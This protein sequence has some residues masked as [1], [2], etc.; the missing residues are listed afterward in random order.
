M[1]GHSLLLDSGTHPKKD[2]KESL[3]EFGLVTKAP[4]AV[5]ISH[6]HIDHCGSVPYLV[7]Q[8]PLARIYATVPTVRIMDRMLHNSVAVMETLARERGIADYPLYT[9]DDVHY[10]MR[11]IRGFDLGVP[12]GVNMPIPVKATFHHAGH[13]LGSASTLLRLPGHTVFYTADICETDQ[14]LMGGFRP[15]DK[16]V[17]IDTLIVE[18]TR[19]AT[20]EHRIKVYSEEI[21]RLSKAVKQ[22]LDQGGAVLIPCFALGRTQEVLNVLA[23]LQEE[24]RIPTVP[25]YASGLGRAMYE[26]YEKYGEYLRPD[27][28]LRSLD[29]FDRI[30]NVYDPR[31]VDELLSHPCIIVATSGMMIENTPSAMIAREMVQQPQ[32]GIFFVGYLDHETL[33]YKL[34][35]AEPGDLLAFTLRGEP[36]ERKLTN[37]ERFDFSS[38]A[39]RQALKDLVERIQPKNVVFVHGDPDAVDWMLANAPGARNSF[40]PRI[41]ETLT[42]ES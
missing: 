41:G 32:H 15:L 6:A 24:G 39:P 18:S 1:D 7:K 36:V 38:H 2:G 33:G 14:E 11:S 34:L 25:I 3:P 27:A 12:F 4:E 5:I 40:A 13:V 28:M 23:R 22:V 17:K 42:L 9:H 31:K 26:I 10:A 8:F 19:G 21:A 30:G 16:S 29:S 35:H 37:I 20:E